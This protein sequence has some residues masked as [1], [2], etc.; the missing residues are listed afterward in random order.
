MM[1]E[2][3]SY[4]PGTPCW[5]DLGSPDL[6]ASVDFYGGLFGWGI[7]GGEDAEQNGGGPPGGAGGAARGPGER[8]GPPPRVAPLCPRGGRRRARGEGEGG[9]RR[10]AGRADGRARP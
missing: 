10:G 8:G 3:T 9:G 5:V 6:D 1:S 2:R 4:A 7:P